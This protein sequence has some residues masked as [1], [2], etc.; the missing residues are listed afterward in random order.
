MKYHKDTYEWHSLPKEWQKYLIFEEFVAM[1]CATDGN[2]Q[3]SAIAKALGKSDAD[4]IRKAI[5]RHIRKLS[6]NEIS[7]ILDSY[8][9]E[10]KEFVGGWDP[11]TIKTKKDLIQ[12]VLQSGFHYQGDSLTLSWFSR[13][14]QIDIV[15]LCEMES[16]L[17]ITQITYESNSQAIILYYKGDGRGGHYQTVGLRTGNKVLTLFPKDNSNI[18]GDALQRVMNRPFLL[19]QHIKA[20]KHECKEK[21][22][23][24]LNSLINSISKSF[25]YLSIDDRRTISK[26]IML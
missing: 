9:A 3:F 11:N 7:H 15:V 22:C 24:T 21:R 16:G 14:Q 2:C 1:D 10:G 19:Q 17:S 18:V 20:A 8:K 4:N 6:N 23:M 12:Q 25:G 13:S 26:S 5:A